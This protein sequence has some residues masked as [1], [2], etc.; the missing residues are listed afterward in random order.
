[1]SWQLMIIAPASW[2]TL[3]HRLCRP[4]ALK[5]LLRSAVSAPGHHPQYSKH[6]SK[7]C[8]ILSHQG[9]P[10]M[11]TQLK[12]N[13]LGTT[14]SFVQGLVQQSESP[15]PSVAFDAGCCEDAED[16]EIQLKSSK[17]VNSGDLIGTFR[18]SVAEYTANIF[19]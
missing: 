10:S 9:P 8:W 6:H 19:L 14:H 15:R 18:I 13:M 16:E 12:S 5:A 7:S 2:T 1:M 4:W 11:M 17:S 3:R